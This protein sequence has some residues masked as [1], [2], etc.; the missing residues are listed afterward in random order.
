MLTWQNPIRIS[1]VGLIM[2][3]KGQLDALEIVKAL[4]DSGLAVQLQFL[5]KLMM[6]RI[7]N[8]SWPLSKRINCKQ[9][10]AGRV[11]WLRMPFTNKRISC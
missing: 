8:N 4:R 7:T 5:E 1:I 10:L 2:P 3:T 6:L 9:E 11:T